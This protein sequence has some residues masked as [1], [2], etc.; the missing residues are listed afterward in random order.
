MSNSTESSSS[1][2]SSTKKSVFE[3]DLTEIGRIQLT[4]KKSKTKKGGNEDNKSIE[5][6][7]Y[8]VRLARLLSHN[9]NEASRVLKS[10]VRQEFGV[11]RSRD[12]IHTVC[13]LYDT[14]LPDIGAQSVYDCVTAPRSHTILIVRGCCDDENCATSTAATAESSEYDSDDR[15]ST[16]L[17]DDDDDDQ[18]DKSHPF[19]DLFSDDDDESDNDDDDEDSDE[20]ET[21]G[22]NTTGVRS[23]LQQNA[24]HT[25]VL[26]YTFIN[27]IYDHILGFK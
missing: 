7:V 11:A 24:T 19:K 25:K 15:L 14:C 23:F 27:C 12:L 22:D 6:R 17:G 10:R 13:A 9:N 1:S 3:N 21:E 4:K 16:V 26:K 8:S 5:C 2:S 20:D 18:N